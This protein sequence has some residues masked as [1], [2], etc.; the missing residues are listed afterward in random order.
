MARSQMCGIAECA[1]SGTGCASAV[2]G[3]ACC[4]SACCVLTFCVLTFFVLRADDNDSVG[5][6][7]AALVVEAEGVERAVVRADIYLTGAAPEA[8]W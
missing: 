4:R 8:A 2:P 1:T 5:R 3:S 7:G 6:G